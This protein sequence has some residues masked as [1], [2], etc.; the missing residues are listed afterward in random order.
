MV[1]LEF[2]CTLDKVYSCKFFFYERVIHLF[3]T[4]TGNYYGCVAN[5]PLQ[6]RL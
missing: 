2:I 5:I 1:R 4:K 3:L 6:K